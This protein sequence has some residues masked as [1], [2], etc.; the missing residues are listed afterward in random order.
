MVARFTTWL[1]LLPSIPFVHI[2]I[3]RKISTTLHSGVYGKHFISPPDLQ[4]AFLFLPPPNPPTGP[5][6]P[7]YFR[8]SFLV[9]LPLFVFSFSA[10]FIILPP[11]LLIPL[12]ISAGGPCYLLELKG[13]RPVKY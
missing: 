1:R 9:V 10:L 13:P 4:N 5:Q 7:P 3:N 8:P 12:I 2:F 11:A 6:G